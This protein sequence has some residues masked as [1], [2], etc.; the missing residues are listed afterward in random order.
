MSSYTT[1]VPDV[2][3]TCWFDLIM[4]TNVVYKNITA[5][6]HCFPFHFLPQT[7]NLP[8]NLYYL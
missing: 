8:L 7:Q 4:I 2:R 5:R 1:L 3:L 6:Y